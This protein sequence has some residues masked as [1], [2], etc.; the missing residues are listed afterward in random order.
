MFDVN[1]SR[2]QMCIL[3]QQM[4]QHVQMLTQNFILTYEHPE[5]HE[6]SEKIKEY[7]VSICLIF[8]TIMHKK[9]RNDRVKMDHNVVVL[10]NFFYK[11]PFIDFMMNKSEILYRLL[12]K[13]KA[14]L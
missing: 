3:E 9:L 14:D 1:F 6:Y 11:I 2:D 4:R 13:W 8:F 12:T 10:F 5:F 7:L